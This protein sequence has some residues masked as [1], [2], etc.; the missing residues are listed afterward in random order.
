MGGD[1]G[2]YSQCL[3]EHH[4]KKAAESEA[5][6]L[7]AVERSDKDVDAIKRV[8]P[9]RERAIYSYLGKLL[10]EKKVY[11]CGYRNI[12]PGV[13]RPVFKFGDGEWAVY[14]L[15]GKTSTADRILH[16]YREKIG[17]FDDP[18]DEMPRAPV[19]VIVRRDPLVSYLFG[20]PKQKE[21]A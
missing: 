2:K 15:A 4:A 10:Y 6:V 11:V 8:V 16:A 9:L 13:Y 19:T 21:A 18:E 14:P 1:M 17:E 3:R 5:L 7:K 12:S 20:E